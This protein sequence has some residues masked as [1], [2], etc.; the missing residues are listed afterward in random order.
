MTQTSIVYN[1]HTAAYVG[2]H[3]EGSGPIFL[4]GVTCNGD[5]DEITDCPSDPEFHYENCTHSF[6]VTLLCSV[7]TEPG[8]TLPL[9]QKHALSYYCVCYYHRVCRRRAE[10]G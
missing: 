9:N 4:S 7:L 5:E 1:T 10:T 8:P 2:L 6:D 3:N